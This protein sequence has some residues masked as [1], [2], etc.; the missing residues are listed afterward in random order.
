ME[1]PEKARTSRTARWPNR[2]RSKLA[3][4]FMRITR[5]PD[6]L[7]LELVTCLSDKYGWAV[8]RVQWGINP[9]GNS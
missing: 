1:S 5:K 7:A 2:L 8:F 4:R 9:L 3:R 6:E